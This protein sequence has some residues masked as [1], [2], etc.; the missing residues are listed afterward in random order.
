MRISNVSHSLVNGPGVR[1]VFWLQGCVHNCKGCFSPDSQK[2]DAGKNVS[3]KKLIQVVD[4]ELR[5]YKFDGITI[6]GG[7]PLYQADQLKVFLKG[8]RI[9][10]PSLNVYMWSGYTLEEINE[11][12]DKKECLKYINTLICDRYVHSERYSEDDEHPL[13]G[14]KNQRIIT[15][16]NGEIKSIEK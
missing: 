2:V 9:K 15:L 13:K 4:E 11:D 14:S 7:D 1:L 12:T 5:D 6:T 16:E 10:R 3:V 8:L